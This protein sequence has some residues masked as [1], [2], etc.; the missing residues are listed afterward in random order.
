LMTMRAELYNA[1]LG[2][3]FRDLR[4]IFRLWHF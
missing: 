3:H 1:R 2:Y 4:D